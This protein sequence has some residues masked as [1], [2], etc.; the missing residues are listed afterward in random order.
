[1]P[2]SGG[3]G[4]HG[5]GF[6]GGGFG[7]S[8]RS[9]YT[10]RR[11]HAYFPGARTFV[12]YRSGKPVYT[13]ADY[14]LIPEKVT[15]EKCRDTVVISLI[16]FAVCAI[17]IFCSFI[18]PK[19]IIIDY[20]DKIVITDNIGVIENES[21]LSKELNSFKKKTGVAP[22]VITVNNEEWQEKYYDD[23]SR[24][25]YDLYVNNF[26]DEKHCLI[27]YS[28]P[29]EKDPNFND[30]YFETMIGDD[31]GRIFTEGKETFLAKELQKNLSDESLDFDESV[32]HAFN[33][34][35]KKITTYPTYRGDFL[36]DSAFLAFI[37]ILIFGFF[38]LT[39]LLKRREYK[40]Y[41]ENPNIFEIMNVDNTQIKEDTCEYCGGLYV[42]GTVLSC[43]HCGAV[44]P[45]HNK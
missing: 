45:P 20:D 4:S 17:L 43:P 40:K 10:N 14:S 9:V 19:P 34:C 28:E 37:L 44:I 42:V 6:H 27:I 12:S 39:T 31:T 32:A 30:W 3:G 16:A 41:I 38:L 36:S 7:S 22:A 18:P 11:S 24:Y 26:E 8:G 1:M 25:A 21:Y 33:A 23:L 5:S 29:A 2:H 15:E 13:Y 35:A